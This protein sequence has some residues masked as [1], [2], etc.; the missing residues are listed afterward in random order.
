M[1]LS[2][3]LFLGGPIRVT[4]HFRLVASDVTSFRV[5]VTLPCGSPLVV[6]GP[7]WSIYDNEQGLAQLVRFDENGPYRHVLFVRVSDGL[8]VGEWRETI[9]RF[10]SLPHM[11][12][13]WCRMLEYLKK[14]A[15]KLKS[16]PTE[17]E[18]IDDDFA[19][20]YPALF[21]FLSANVT[22][23]GELRER[24]K[25]QLFVEGGAWKACLMDAGNEASLFTTL[26]SPQ[27]CWEGIE[28]ALTAEKPDWRAWRKNRKK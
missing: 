4:S 13:G 15:S 19:K 27:K 22:A 3:V 28:K 26:G 12:E 5:V 7:P 18:I 1:L 20:K 6:N 11:L 2:P 8:L 10:N 23:D 21:C 25:L 9:P 16:S 14:A 24:C 17:F